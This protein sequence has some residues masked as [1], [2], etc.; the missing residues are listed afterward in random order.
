MKNIIILIFCALLAGCGQEGLKMEPD[1]VDAWFTEN[2]NKIT[3]IVQDFRNEPCLRRVE[4]GSMEYIKQHCD[5]TPALEAK[6]SNIQSK[7]VELK[8]VLATSYLAKDGRFNTSVLIN[9]QGIAVSGGG[10]AIDYW[11]SLGPHWQRQIECGE[12]IPLSKEGWYAEILHSEP[13]CAS[14]K[15]K[16][17]TIENE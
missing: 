6:I 9:R 17:V 7:L 16:A 4:L 14:N 13:S 3:S 5:S 8:V 2:E 12:L 11:S 1:Q 15:A 10:L